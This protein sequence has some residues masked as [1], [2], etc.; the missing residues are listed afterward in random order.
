MRLTLLATLILA[1]II[2]ACSASAAVSP[3]APA[4]GD[5]TAETWRTATL[6]DVLT[7]DEFTIRDLEGKVVVIEPMAIWCVNCRFQQHEAQQALEELGSNDVVYVSLDVDPRERA[8]DL[9]A[10]AQREGFGWRFAVA[11][12]E[13]SRALAKTFGDQVLSPPAT[14]LVV[15]A[16]DGRVVEQHVGG[17]SAAALVTLLRPHLP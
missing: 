7:G 3:A 8:D 2:G 4:A 13:V 14:P 15:L 6:R 1:V 11:S 12:P 17:R 10:Y 5:A 9:S 16:P